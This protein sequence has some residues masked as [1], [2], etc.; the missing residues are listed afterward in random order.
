M[1]LRET[2]E[3]SDEAAALIVRKGLEDELQRLEADHLLDL[4]P[5][6]QAEQDALA[7]IK[8]AQAELRSALTAQGDAIAATASCSFHYDR[9]R[10]A[11]ERDLRS[12]GA[13]HEE[14]HCCCS[15]PAPSP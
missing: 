13:H 6:H 11:L 14:H 5:L 12:P 10:K 8:K 3:R 2:L 15:S 9:Q 4:V 1:T 7:R